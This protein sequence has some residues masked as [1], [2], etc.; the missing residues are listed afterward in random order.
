VLRSWTEWR[1][2]LRQLRPQSR[3]AP[4]HGIAIGRARVDAAGLVPAADGWRAEWVR[5]E[6]PAHPL[7]ERAPDAALQAGLT[8]LWIRLLPEAARSCRPVHVALPDAALRF[9]LF[10]VEVLPRGEPA[11]Q[12]LVSW[13]FAREH[14]LG[15][16]D[17]AY[18]WKCLG[19]IGGRQLLLAVALPRAWLDV[20]RESLRAAGVVAW[21]MDALMRY[22]LNFALPRF[23]AGGESAALLAVEHEFWT[24]TV[25]D[26]A[27][28]PRF[29]RARWRNATSG[30]DSPDVAEE[31][32]RLLRLYVTGQHDRQL[33]RIYVMGSAS[34][35][36]AIAQALDTGLQSP[37]IRLATAIG[38][39]GTTS[40]NTALVVGAAE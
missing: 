7:F 39:E 20:L 31:V 5:S 9:A 29:V 12:Q 40:E 10:E 17:F 38:F 16:D 26:T 35:L 1:T 13:L 19:D 15:G 34:D 36:G 25:V 30:A 18:S 2:R 22:R 28:R 24:L 4:R 11:Q 21:T 33:A 27:H 14:Q 32:E 37:T 23:A 3:P 6:A 8:D